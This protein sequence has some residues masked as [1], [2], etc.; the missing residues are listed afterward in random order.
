MFKFGKRT[1]A[2]ETNIVNVGWVLDPEWEASVI[3]SAP[4]KLPR[5][6]ARS[7]HAKSISQCPAVNDHEARIFELTAPIDIHLRAGRNPKGEAVWA[8]IDGPQSSIRLPYLNKL[9]QMTP[10]AEWRHPGRPM[11]QVFTPYYFVADE[12]VYINSM[13]AFYHYTSRP[14]PGLVLG[15]RFPIHIW[16][17]QMSWAF[18]WCDPDKD[19][20]INRGDP[21]LYL[22]FETANPSR[23]IRLIE[24]TM[25]DDL[26][27]YLK[28]I[29]NVA[30]YVSQTF[31][32]FKTAE[33]RR[34]KTLL[35]PKQR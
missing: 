16:P 1:E 6:E 30:A 4:R 22:T 29:H 25:T 33:Q 26:R 34:P 20:L 3:W 10:E 24:A 35:V 5:S 14:L 19:I 28:E 7:N 13:P 21:W 18:E 9:I 15:G 17:R 2:A 27:G 8:A 32:L 31:S 23:H 12:P 11:F